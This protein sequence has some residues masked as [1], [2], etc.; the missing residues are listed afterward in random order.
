MNWLSS[1]LCLE[2]WF[3]IALLLDGLFVSGCLKNMTNMGILIIV[4]S[5]FN[6][7]YYLTLQNLFKFRLDVCLGAVIGNYIGLTMA[8]LFFS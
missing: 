6:I 3:K 8:M 2:N 1:I 5:I 4:I 7:F